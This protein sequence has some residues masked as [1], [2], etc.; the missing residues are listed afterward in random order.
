ERVAGVVLVDAH[1]GD[2]GFAAEMAATLSLTGAERDEM[3][4][5]SFQSWLGRNSERKRSRLAESAEALVHRTSL[6]EDMRHTSPLQS[7][8]LRD[9]TAPVLAIYGEQ[10]NLRERGQAFLRPLPKCRLVVL[11]GCTHSVLWEATE[12]VKARIVAF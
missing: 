9:V 10:S 7:E 1:L 6:V 5:K 11:P 4:A 12:E 8:A 2:D 3:I